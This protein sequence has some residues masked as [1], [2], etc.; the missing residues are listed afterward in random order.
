MN[1]GPSPV[2]ALVMAAGGR[3]DPLCRTVGACCRALIPVGGTAMVVRTVAA[4]SEASLV[5]EVCVVSPPGGRE[6]FQGLPWKSPP[7]LVEVGDKLGYM[8]TILAGL[9]VF[10]DAER[11]LI[12]T[13]DIPLLRSE[14]VDDFAG[15]ALASGA[16]LCYSVVSYQRCRDLWPGTERTYVRMRDGRFTGGNMVLATPELLRR[17]ADRIEA[18]F[19]ARKHPLRLGRWLG[20]GFLLRFAAGLCT[21]NDVAARAERLLDCRA[22][23]VKSEHPELAFDIDKLTDLEEA[24]RILRQ[25]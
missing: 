1:S 15:R 2:P 8:D 11:L 19:Q 25:T 10:P 17:H 14:I 3:E 18:A 22:F 7:R 21:V 9:D 24:Q 6:L 16:D 13:C 5:Q 12:L 4:L 23:V 20:F